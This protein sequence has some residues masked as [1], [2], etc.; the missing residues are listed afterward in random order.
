MPK[1][2]TISEDFLD[3]KQ[4]ELKFLPSIAN[5]YGVAEGPA[6]VNFFK[7][8]LIYQ[9]SFG[10]KPGKKEKGSLY[11]GFI[12]KGRENEDVEVTEEMIEMQKCLHALSTQAKFNF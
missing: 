1:N 6:I 8:K 10:P 2:S 5:K 12:K 11:E 3:L 9:F 4:Y 7:S